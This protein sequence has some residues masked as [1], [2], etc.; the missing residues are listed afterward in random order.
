MMVLAGASGSGS[1]ECTRG[2]GFRWTDLFGSSSSGNS[3]T[4]GH[5]VG[6][7]E[8]S[9][10]KSV[11]H[12]P[13]PVAP[14][15]DQPA[16]GRPWIPEDSNQ[17]HLMPVEERMK[18]L[19]HRLDINSI[20]QKWSQNQWASIIAAQISVDESIEIALVED[21]YH[22][23]AILAK[24]DRIKGFIFFCFSF[25]ISLFQS[26]ILLPSSLALIPMPP[27]TLFPPM[28]EIEILG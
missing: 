11:P 23:E 12:S 8:A 28:E 16:R 1:G 3:E 4:S 14:E 20:T 21:G 24:R 26:V 22:P 2:R 10:N 7:S 19:G 9:I 13:E 6:S 27:P 5:S 18:E 17:N 25:S 15:A